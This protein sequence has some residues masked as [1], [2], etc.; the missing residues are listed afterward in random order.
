MDLIKSNDTNSVLF[1]FLVLKRAEQR[2]A[3][4]RDEVASS[5]EYKELVLCLN[6]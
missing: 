5:P 4:I 6:Y 2:L 1:A 3:A